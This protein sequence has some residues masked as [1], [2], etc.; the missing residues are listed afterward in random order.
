MPPRRRQTS[1]ILIDEYLLNFQDNYDE[2]ML[3][4]GTPTRSLLRNYFQMHGF[5]FFNDGSVITSTQKKEDIINPDRHG[6]H[7]S[8]SHLEHTRPTALQG[9]LKGSFDSDSGRF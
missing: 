6:V 2:I 9:V 4:L 1:R 7:T 8:S 5:S 3:V